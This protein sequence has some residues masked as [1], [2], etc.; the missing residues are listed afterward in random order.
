MRKLLSIVFVIAM[1]SCVEGQKQKKETNIPSTCFREASD[2]WH[3]FREAANNKDTISLKKILS[4]KYPLDSLSFLKYKNPTLEVV[5]KEELGDYY[6]DFD[7]EPGIR[8]I[9]VLLKDGNKRVDI[10]ILEMRTFED[11]YQVYKFYQFGDTNKMIKYVTKIQTTPKKKEYARVTTIADGYDVQVVN[12]WSSTDGSTR[13]V[14]GNCTN[15]E[16]VEVL[17]YS[18]PYV[19]VRKSNGVEGYFMRE[20]LK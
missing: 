17:S 20:F 6:I 8:K 11:C 13:K 4:D 10:R 5:M 19:Y 7:Y 18:D 12:L 14:V 3:F 16:R 9:F 15:N 1:I 2:A